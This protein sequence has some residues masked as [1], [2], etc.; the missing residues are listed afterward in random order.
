MKKIVIFICIFISLT[1]F[2]GCASDEKI[3]EPAIV[4][5]NLPLPD[6]IDEPSDNIPEP[7]ID[8]VPYSFADNPTIFDFA[9]LPEDA[10]PRGTWT[11]NQLI[12]KYGTPE[13]VW[14]YYMPGY[15][16]VYVS[17]KFKEMGV[18]FYHHSAEDFSFYK[19]D[20]ESGE[21]DLDEKDETLG[22]TINALRIYDKD[23]QLPYG[24]RLYE[25]TK[26]EIIDAYGE[27][28]AYYWKDDSEVDWQEERF[29]VDLIEYFYMFLNDNYGI[30]RDSDYV[31]AYSQIDENGEIVY[32]PYHINGMIT[33]TFD[34]NEVLS[35]FNVKWWVYDL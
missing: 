7:E 15:E 25:S 32:E 10:F 21:Y 8:T 1:V 31:N 16:I 20:L 18:G 12:G 24:I 34:E 29:T 14:G 26:A 13:K 11:V 35:E 19:E 4:E 28:P 33:Y 3:E 30:V 22:L 2:N 9:V 5:E 27:E 17:V 6:I 23:Y